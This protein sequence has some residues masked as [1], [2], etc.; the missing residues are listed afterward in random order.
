MHQ[1]LSNLDLLHAMAVRFNINT[2]IA[3]RFVNYTG[4]VDKIGMLK[5]FPAEYTFLSVKNST[6]VFKF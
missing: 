1:E 3:I 4:P 2:H 6:N 5:F